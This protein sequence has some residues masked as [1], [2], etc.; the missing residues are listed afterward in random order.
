MVTTQMFDHAARLRSFEIVAAV[1]DA[2]AP[3]A[4]HAPVGGMNSSQDEGE[5]GMTYTLYSHDG[6][7]GCCRRGG[8]SKAGAAHKV[9]VVDTGKGEAEPA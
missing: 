2:L 1:R 5:S 6:S 4:R 7:G 8:T 9:V 3:T